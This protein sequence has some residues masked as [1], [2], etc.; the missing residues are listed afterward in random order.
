MNEPPTD[1]QS[2]GA[3]FNYR[4]LLAALGALEGSTAEIRFTPEGPGTSPV[5]IIEPATDGFRLQVVM[6]MRV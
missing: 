1:G 5:C 6:P 2:F 4:Y 3:A